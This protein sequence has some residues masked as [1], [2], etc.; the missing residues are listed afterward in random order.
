MGEVLRAI[1]TAPDFI[2]NVEYQRNK[3][4]T[5]YEFVVGV[6]RALG[7]SPDAGDDDGTFFERFRTGAVN[8]GYDPFTFLVPTGLPENGDAWMNSAAL[9]GQYRSIVDV[10]FRENDY[11]FDVGTMVAD[12]GLVTAEEVA[13]YLLTIATADRFTL[14]EYEALIEL[15]KDEDG[16]FDPVGQNED[17]AYQRAVGLLVVLPSLQLQ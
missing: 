16:I 12:A 6:I 2:T 17:E 15:L 11:N 10:S 3:G 13:A 7:M 1:L 4:R 8:A 5:P 14:E 9:M